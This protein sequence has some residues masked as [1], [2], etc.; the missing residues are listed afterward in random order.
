MTKVMIRSKGTVLA[1]R[2]A[3]ADVAFESGEL[4][5]IEALL[6]EWDRPDALMLEMQAH[7]DERTVRGVVSRLPDCSA[8]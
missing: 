2:G 5:R 7:I 4:P 3:V 8:A 6:I 1:V